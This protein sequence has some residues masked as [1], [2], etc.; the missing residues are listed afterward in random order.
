MSDQT[1]PNLENIQN[2]VTTQIQTYQ[3]KKGVQILAEQ[4]T[5]ILGMPLKNAQM[6]I[7]P[8]ENGVQVTEISFGLLMQNQ[9][10]LVD[11]LMKLFYE[12]EVDLLTI[13][14]EEYSRMEKEL[15][16]KNPFGVFDIK[17]K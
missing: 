9:L 1:I 16:Q 3:L 11:Y 5:K 6:R 10:E 14:N 12:P 15:K 8:N 4:R 2:E 7:F 13:S 17:L